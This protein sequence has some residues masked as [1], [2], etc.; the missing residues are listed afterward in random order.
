MSKRGQAETIGIIALVAVAVAIAVAASNIA[1]MQEIQKS[2]KIPIPIDDIKIEP[3]HTEC[4][5]GQTKSCGINTGECKSGTQTCTSS[6]TWGSCQGRIGPIVEICEDNKDNDCDGKTDE[7]CEAPKPIIEPEPIKICE[8]GEA[9]QCGTTDTGECSYGTQTCTSDSWG[10]CTG[11]VTPTTETCDNK[12]NDCDGQTDEDLTQSCGSDVGE[13]KK[14]TK[15]CAAGSWGTC[16]GE[17]KPVTETCD[18]KDNDCDNQV[19]EGCGCIS[20]QTQTCGSS[21]GECKTGTQTCTNG[22]W[23]TC[24]GETTPVTE[25]CDNK[26][27]DCDG[28]T[29]ESLTQSCGSDTG[30]C[31][32]GIKT[33]TAGSWG[34]C[35]G[36]IT[37]TT[38]TCDNKDNDCDGQVD[39]NL[40]STTC[41]TGECRVTV[42]NCISGVSQTCTPKTPT[43][44]I[45]DSKDNDCDGQTDEDNVCVPDFYCGD[46]TCDAG[47]SSI[48]CCTDCGCPSETTCTNNACIRQSY[49][50]DGLCSGDETCSSCQQDCG[51]CVT[52]DCTSGLCCD[53]CN[54]RPSTY[55]CQEDVTTDYGC[56]WGTSCGANVGVRHQDR[57]CSGTSSSCNGQLVW[58]SWTIA[59]TCTST[60]TCTD[61]IQTCTYDSTCEQGIPA[62][63]EGTDT[64]CGN[65]PYCTNCNIQDGCYETYYRDYSCNTKSCTYI[66]DNCN[67]CSC[68]CGGYN[69]Q[70]TLNNANCEDGKDNDCDGL[71]DQ[72]DPDCVTLPPDEEEVPVEPEEPDH[73]IIGY[74]VKLKDDPIIEYKIKRATELKKINSLDSFTET[75]SLEQDVLTYRKTTLK[76]HKQVKSE[77]GTIIP[78][79]KIFAEYKNAF[80]GFSIDITEE[81]AKEISK[82]PEVEE[83]FPQYEVKP[84]LFDSVPLI[85]AD[86]V[87]QLQDEQGRQITG[88][89]ITVAVIDTGVDYTH[90]DL[91]GCFG[92][93]CKVVG[94]WDLVDDDNNPMDEHGHGTHV[95]STVAGNGI[96][97]G[98]A[99]DAIVYAY[100]VCDSE[101]CSYLME[102]VDKALDPDDDGDFSDH[103]DIIQL[104]IGGYGDPDD[105]FSQQIDN[106]VDAGVVAVIAAGNSGPGGDESCKHEEDLTG[107]SYSICSPG[108]A[109]KAITVAA[110]NKND[111]IAGFSSRGPT[112]LG[113]MKPDI[114]AP[115]VSICAAQWDSFAEQVAC[116]DDKH[117]AISGTSMATPHVSGAAAILLEYNSSFSPDDILSILQNTG[118]N[119][120]GWRRINVTSAFDSICQCT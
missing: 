61:N 56:P 90:P 66:S 81:E 99:P 119:I 82:L 115:G 100:R 118:K 97:K 98:V 23:G 26:D 113:T 107:S 33:C 93:G 114:T 35:T 78:E 101:R 65:Y 22:E 37:S 34:S 111:I 38:E 27:N 32:K 120:G 70:E 42:N 85:N 106:V 21:T 46:G 20:G 105:P 53:G 43:T 77:I 117:I 48:N 19:D 55:K 45:C 96:L 72:G 24:T 25:I 92:E 64:S 76:K 39:E 36:E 68:S 87:W 31:Q 80:N 86:D 116:L 73:K 30:T 16:T 51:S 79:D 7:G 58:D 84:L 62:G 60:E 63:C 57:Y 1:D 4:T 44:E 69:T 2:P 109:R 5:P 67:D 40:G 11:E 91:G 14:G 50:G 89:G 52:C 95:A 3:E 29:D 10:P 9:K 18:G 104:S 12:D 54:F 102:G 6:G 8:D 71:T 13:C 49:C 108:T 28:Q 103:V 17:I 74:I 94:G 75:S 112:I 47:E 110:S 59:D 83:V 88:E 15:T 41:G